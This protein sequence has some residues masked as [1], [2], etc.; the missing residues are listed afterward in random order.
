MAALVAFATALFAVVFLIPD[1][2]SIDH[3]SFFYIA[4]HSAWNQLFD[5]I[6]VWCSVKIILLGIAIILL[7]DA[8]ASLLINNGSELIGMIFF[9]SIIFPMLLF[10]FGLYELVKATL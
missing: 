9:A 4:L 7:I 8:V 6:A 5:W 2:N 1:G 10:A 3:Q